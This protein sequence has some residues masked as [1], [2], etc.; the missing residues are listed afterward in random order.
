MRGDIAGD[1]LV[2]TVFGQVDDS[3]AP[4]ERWKMDVEKVVR[5]VSLGILCQC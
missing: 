4:D 2:W 5:Q 1:A 3:D